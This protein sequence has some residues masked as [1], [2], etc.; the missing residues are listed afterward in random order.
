MYMHSPCGHSHACH[1]LYSTCIIDVLLMQL[2]RA[3]TFVF[4]IACF[5]WLLWK[6]NQWTIY[7]IDI[8][9]REYNTIMYRIIMILEGRIDM[10]EEVYIEGSIQV[11]FQLLYFPQTLKEITL[12]F[13]VYTKSI[14]EMSKISF[15][16]RYLCNNR[17][18]NVYIIEHVNRSGLWLRLIL[19]RATLPTYMTL[20]VF[21]W[22]IYFFKLFLFSVFF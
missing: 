12:S 6:A 16:V 20:Y 17:A 22:Q 5:I 14:Y 13:T 19:L 2:T 10:L 11:Y 18:V 1:T 7:H 9:R 8:L 3:E 15:L 4:N 21:Y